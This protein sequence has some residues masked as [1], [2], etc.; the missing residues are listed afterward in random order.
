MLK[1]MRDLSPSRKATGGFTLVEMLV[2]IVV[3]G[4]L[5]A[6]AVP[7]FLD[8]SAKADE[9]A[10][11][12]DLAN[13]ARM[14]TPAYGEGATLPT[15]FTAGQQ[16]QVTGL[17]GTVYG[18]LTPNATLRVDTSNGGLCVTGSAN[19]TDWQT[20][21]GTV[22]QG[23]CT[24]VSASASA[25]GAPFNL[26]A[27]AGTGQV[28]LVWS[29]PQDD[30]GDTVTGYT[31]E[32]A[33]SA[34]GPWTEFVAG[35]SDTFATI[36]G[37]TNGTGYYFQVTATNRVGEGIASSA[38]ATPVAPL[39]LSYA[40]TSFTSGSNNETLAATTE[41]GLGDKTYSVSGTLPDGVT[42]NSA[43]GTFT[44]PASSGWNFTAAQISAGSSHTC[45]V[46]T[47]GGAKCWGYNY[48]GQ[49]GDGNG[50]WGATSTSPVD[51]VGLTSGVASIT[52]AG[53]HT[54]AVTTT[55]GAKCWGRNTRGQLGDGSTT[56]RTTPVDV[57][58]L[59]SG[60]ASI[61]A[62]GEHTCAVTTTG[63][64][65]CWG[66]NQYG[67][68]GNG[69]TTAW[70][71]STPTPVDVSGLTSGVASI[72]THIDHTCAV[73]TTGGAK[74]WG[75]NDKGQLGDGSTTDRT[76]PVDV[77]GLTSGVASISVGRQH[78]CAVTT[79][80]GAKCWGD[81][82]YGQVGDGSTTKRTTPVDVPGLTSGVTSIAG[83]G[84][85]TCAVIN[86]EP[87][88]WGRNNY[89]QLGNNTT[90]QSLTPVDVDA[91]STPAGFPATVDVTVTD[92]TGSATES[93]TL[94]VD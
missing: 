71:A 42:F 9:A 19:G 66:R 84:Y 89:G 47:T 15:Q 93:V 67:Q 90:T 34:E 40:D 17:D 52:A 82:P 1:V 74:C 83:G 7:I 16:T 94:S 78:T 56:E 50:S 45:A 36:T 5:A 65:K 43:T 10:L 76:T 87:K 13:A 60:V 8:Q 62:S 23:S 69:T 4:L 28:A 49:L 53:V 6:I 58:G 18:A 24:L 20:A 73:T 63:G 35:T 29:V 30:G 57:S 75:H 81:N 46:T 3:I 70:N 31:V 92:D 51:V 37:L 38:T 91:A 41:G 86:G 39:A 33:T 14:L 22:S 2:V 59:T 88:C 54:C 85:H 72:S 80:G 48:Y 27:T 64:A 77:S 61:S 11:K 25:P 21:G 79:T 12:S 68:L 26:N 55:G 44:G 32:Y